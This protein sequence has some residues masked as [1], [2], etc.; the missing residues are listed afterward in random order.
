M[1]RNG[2]MVSKEPTDAQRSEVEKRGEDWLHRAFSTEPLEHDRVIKVICELY[3]LAGRQSPAVL[4]CKSPM[5]LTAA[6]AL[7]AL[8]VK[9]DA[10][11]SSWTR[12]ERLLPDAWWD[13]LVSELAEQMTLS[14]L[15]EHLRAEREDVDTTRRLSPTRAI[16]LFPQIQFSAE[17]IETLDVKLGS[18]LNSQLEQHWSRLTTSEMRTSILSSTLARR[19]TFLS[20]Q[21]RAELISQSAAKVIKPIGHI[22]REMPNNDI[23]LGIPLGT[24]CKESP[25]II[26]LYR[27]HNSWGPWMIQWPSAYLAISDVFGKEV[28]GNEGCQAR[29]VIAFLEELQAM[30]SC[31]FLKGLCVVSERPQHLALDEQNRVHDENGAAIVFADG[32]SL[33]SW[34]G[35]TV[36]GHAI[37]RPKALTVKRIQGER[38]SATRRALIDIYGNTKFLIDSGATKVHE[39]DFGVLYRQPL[40]GDEALVMVKVINSTPEPDGTYKDYFIRVP[41]NIETAHEA[42]AWTFSVDAGRYK[43]V[44]QT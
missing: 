23:S 19:L 1:F 42:V 35:V 40:Q 16:S 34:R 21:V 9:S 7:L 33:Y 39:D 14:Q 5:Q 44:R 38:N 12:L 8:L 30:F 18:V 13:E 37:L 41:P 20:L 3:R 24:F 43:P 27:E 4:F 6:S 15:R 31:V 26:R 29:R 11:V 22:F 25:D 36:P 32:F 28:F 17:L 10:G 2:L